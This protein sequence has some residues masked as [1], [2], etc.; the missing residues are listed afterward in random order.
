MEVENDIKREKITT[1]TGAVLKIIKR[2]FNNLKPFKIDNK[3][4][5]SPFPYPYFLEAVSSNIY[6]IVFQRFTKKKNT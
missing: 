4:L 6:F 3:Y 2:N 1:G 5:I